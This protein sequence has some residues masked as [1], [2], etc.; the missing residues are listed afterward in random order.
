MLAIIT[1]NIPMHSEILVGELQEAG[2][3]SARVALILNPS[4]GSFLSLT[5]THRHFLLLDIT[6]FKPL[7][8]SAVGALASP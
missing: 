2:R 6:C 3:L 5:R 1:I 4:E 7:Q 8:Q